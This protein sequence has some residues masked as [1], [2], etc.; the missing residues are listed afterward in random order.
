MAIVPHRT[1]DR[2][3]GRRGSATQMAA[4][5][6]AGT[7][8]AWPAAPAAGAAPEAAPRGSGAQYRLLSSIP[9]QP[10][11]VG[12]RS[13][14]G[15]GPEALQPAAG[16]T[17]GPATAG[18][19]APGDPGHARFRLDADT[20]FDHYARRRLWIQRHVD[21]IK[22]YPPFGDVYARY[23]K[24]VIGYHD[25]ATEGFAPLNQ[26]QVEAFVSKVRRDMGVGYAG[27]FV[28][29][30]NWSFSPSPGPEANLANLL[31]AIRKAEPAALI[32]INSQYH[33]IWP[34][35]KAGDANVARALAQVN[36]VTKEF[37]VGPEAGITSAQDYAEFMTYADT[38]R[39]KGIHVVMSGESSN[40][41]P[42]MEY[43]LAT[44]L[45]INDGGDYVNTGAVK[46]RRFWKGFA[47]DLGAALGPRERSSSGLWS[48]HFA[49]GVVYTVERGAP[50]QTIGLGRKMHSAEWG[51]VESV[52]LGPEQGA[53]LSG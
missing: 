52:T 36:L 41:V 46:L 28:D 15:A 35:L 3:R 11:E 16:Q 34:K 13:G 4:L 21:V 17:A 2:A 50:T 29:D 32:E 53:V 20:S 33:D 49:R 40:Y 12:E 25:P 38:L 51:T 42:T 31:E 44:C 22:A 27:V 24:A 19:A 47:A 45:L 6:A 18:A 26:S 1:S 30:A 43:N 37:G 23:G 14:A 5:L 7:A 9:G 39:A 48:R 8:A 10:T